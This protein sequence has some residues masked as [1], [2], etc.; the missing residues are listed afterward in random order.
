MEL[1]LLL[2]TI[3]CIALVCP[4]LLNCEDLGL[5]TVLDQYLKVSERICQIEASQKDLMH[6]RSKVSK[7]TKGMP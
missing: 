1:Y 3:T 4:G 7:A 6:R 2:L 5:P